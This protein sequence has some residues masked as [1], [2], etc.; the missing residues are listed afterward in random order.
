M[1]LV[2]SFKI[3]AFLSN[4]SCHLYNRATNQ[5]KANQEAEEFS[6]SK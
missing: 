4:R 2:E 3:N 5:S 1:L 6:I